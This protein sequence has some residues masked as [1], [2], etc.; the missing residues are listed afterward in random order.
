MEQSQELDFYLSLKGEFNEAFDNITFERYPAI[1]KFS[2]PGLRL[3]N[4]NFSMLLNSDVNTEEAIKWVKSDPSRKL[5]V[6]KEISMGEMVPSS[7]CTLGVRSKMKIN[8]PI[9]D[10]GQIQ[11]YSYRTNQRVEAIR[12]IIPTI[13]EMIDTSPEYEKLLNQLIGGVLHLNNG[14]IWTYEIDDGNIIAAAIEETH[15]DF[16]KMRSIELITVRP[17]FRNKGYASQLIQAILSENWKHTFVCL[18][19]NTDIF[20]HLEEKFHF[21]P[22]VKFGVYQ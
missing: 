16:E 2:F 3:V 5:L 8:F 19:E 1:V 15:D 17:N 21:K 4:Q 13:S 6:S 9:L 7:N 18:Y 12:S 11:S 10:F 22:I 20:S 14:K